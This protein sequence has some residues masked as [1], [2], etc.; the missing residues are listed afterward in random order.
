MVG[1]VDILECDRCLHCYLLKV[2]C[3]LSGNCLRL[4]DGKIF[5]EFSVLCDCSSGDIDIIT[6]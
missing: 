2:D 5:N 3:Y 4:L 1:G 6:L